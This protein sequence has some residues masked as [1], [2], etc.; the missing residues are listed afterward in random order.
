VK[1][2]EVG[3]N[4]AWAVF[5][6]ITS[7]RVLSDIIRQTITLGGD[8]DSVGCLALGIA[9]ARAN[10]TKEIENDLPYFLIRDLEPHS[11]FGTKF[12]KDLGKK[13]MIK[14]E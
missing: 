13:L 1:G 7:C 8:T 11:K 4:T 10:V 3:I 12:L 6:L 14:Y 2:P 5:E 9:S